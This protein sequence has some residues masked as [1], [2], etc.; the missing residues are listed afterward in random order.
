MLTVDDDKVEFVGLPDK[1]VGPL[2]ALPD[3]AKIKDPLLAI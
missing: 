1:F 2:S 3:E